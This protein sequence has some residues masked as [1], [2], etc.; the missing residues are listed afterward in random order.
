MSSS[1]VVLSRSVS[2]SA[3]ATS[4]EIGAFTPGPSSRHVPKHMYATSVHVD[5][6]SP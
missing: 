3:S 4:S 1:H 6:Y 2:L 5:E